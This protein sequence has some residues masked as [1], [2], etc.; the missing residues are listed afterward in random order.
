M[1]I[2]IISIHIIIKSSSY[3]ALSR[4]ISIFTHSKLRNSNPSKEGKKSL[5][6]KVEE[7]SGYVFLGGSDEWFLYAEYLNG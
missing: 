7:E 1:I 2:N 4:S 6:G 5:K 3:P